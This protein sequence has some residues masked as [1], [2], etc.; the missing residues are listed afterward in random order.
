MT[1]VPLDIRPGMGSD[2]SDPGF[3]IYVHWPF[4][5]AKCPYCDFN[6]HVRHQPVDQP[7]F[8]Q[9]FLKEM[10]T[11]R[12]LTGSRSVTSIFM[13][14]GT[15]SLM[16]PETVDAI[17]NGIA[18]HWHVPDGIEITM[19][20]NPSSVE[21]ERF[22]G[23][24]AAGVNRVSLGVQ[25][26]NDRDLK[27]LGRLHDVADALKA[28]RLA[29]DIFPRMS[30]DLIYARPNQTVAEWDRELKEAVSYAVDHLSLYQ[31]TIEE[32]TPFY[33]LHKA[34][35]LV[36]P[37]GE[38]SAVLYEATQEITE[39]ENMPAY[40]VSNHARPGAESRH[41]LTYWRYGDYV[42]IGP[43][44][45]GRLTTGGAKIATATER[46]PEGWLELVEA[47]G[48]GMIDQELLEREAQ[49]DE[50]LLMGLRLK[51]GV[52]LARWQMLSGRDPDPDREQFLI[53]H[54][55][56]ER[57]GNSRLRCTPAGMLIL[58]AVVADL[59]C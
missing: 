44:A 4:C 26:L 1:A 46:K 54:G 11:M 48:H 31:L 42:G 32:G 37:D 7:R 27:F 20:A 23:Y 40:E 29:R 19:E 39:R 14:G 35:K 15:P 16:A 43:G 9:A 52:D 55:F 6:S 34:G 12:R 22:R 41:N 38:Q 36:V 10:A 17:L 30:F 21:A 33:G 47:Q 13:G 3:G 51:E 8:V 59:A 24:R 2:L 25:A 45:H 50:L 58:D 56:I 28:I 49:A 57:L 53:E 18:R 5:A